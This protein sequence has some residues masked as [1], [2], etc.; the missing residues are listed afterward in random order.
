VVINVVR[1]AWSAAVF[2]MGN[3]IARRRVFINT[4][5]NFENLKGGILRM[6]GWLNRIDRIQRRAFCFSAHY[7]RE[8]GRGFSFFVIKT[9]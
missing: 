1:L 7:S 9:T 5:A 6:T 2:S 4:E 8:F 3:P